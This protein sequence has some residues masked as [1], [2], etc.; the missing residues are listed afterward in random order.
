ME[1]FLDELE[2]AP[3][4]PIVSYLNEE[5]IVEEDC[6]FFLHD[7]SHDVFTF[8]IEEKDRET[9]PFLQDG[10]V[11]EEPKE[12]LSAHFIVYP[13]PVYGQVSSGIG[14][15]AS[16]LHP[17]VHSE[18]IMPQVNNHEGREMFSDQLNSPGI[19]YCD[20]VGAYME[21]CFPKALEP[22]N[23][24]PFSAFGGMNNIPSLVFILLTYLPNIL[25]SIYSKERGRITEQSGWL[26]WKFSFA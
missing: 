16:V 17:L 20:P 13:E 21:W 6:S 12:Q 22:I 4:E 18:D 15:P 11:Q 24:F 7:I 2:S 10:G 19:I 8:W 25:W 3:D 14:Q 5:S 26:W 9:V 23:L 1:D